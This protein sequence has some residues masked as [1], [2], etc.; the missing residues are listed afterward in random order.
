MN[1][2]LD[3]PADSGFG[4]HNLP[5][6]V[7]SHGDG[8]ARVGVRLGDY[9]V[10]LAAL[11][12]HGLVAAAGAGR[13]P[14]FSQPALNAFMALGPDAWS[15]VRERLQ[16]LLSDSGDPALREGGAVREAAVL[17]LADVTMHL[18][19]R[20]GD[21]TDFYSSRQHA[22]NVGT[23]FRG[24]E[25]ALKPNWLHLPVGY[26]GRASS[27]VVS[28]TDVVRPS[29]QTRPDDDAP[30]TFGPSK[31]LDI[32]LELGFFVGPGNELGDPI[33]ISDADRHIFG[34]V[35]VN[36]WSARDIQKWEYVPL[37]PFLGKSFATSVSPWVVPYEALAPF[38]VDGEPQDATAGNPE[39]LPYLRQRGP[40]ALDVDLEVRLQ[41]SSM[42]EGGE[43]VAQ[44]TARNLYWS[45]EQQLA[46]HTVNG[47][48]A[49]P[50]DLMASG[51]ISGEDPG[52]YGSLL[53]MTWSGKNPLS[54]PGGETRT[55]LED[56]DRVTITGEA[57]RDGVAVGF[58][59]VTGRVLPPRP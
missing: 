16:D 58:G 38:R 12:T 14:V 22:T 57:R 3:V 36:D 54:L 37:G 45:P 11:E 30:P 8:G 10:D 46:H 17:P 56:G 23:M 40:R 43:V 55:F 33:S 21:Y 53:E 19:A 13:A 51:T 9:V 28:G 18:P 52:S 1:P 25:N 6:G 4:L 39:P 50:G 47:C 2:F 20:I 24:P 34:F 5:Y 7:F 26:H 48:N 15:A 29:G 32:E 35:L 42:D 41:T 49:R 44:T 59:E 31:R 27:V